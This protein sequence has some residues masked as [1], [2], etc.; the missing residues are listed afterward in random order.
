MFDPQKL[1]ELPRQT[2]MAV[3]PCGTW[4]AVGQQILNKD[5]TKYTN[6]LVRLSLADGSHQLLSTGES[7]RNPTFLHDGRLGFLSN[8]GDDEEKKHTQV[9]AFPNGVGEPQALTQEPLGVQSFVAASRSNVLVC[10]ANMLPDVAFDDQRKTMK[11]RKDKGSSALVYD[12]APVRYWDHWLP[13][14]HTHVVVYRDGQRHDLTPQAGRELEHTAVSVSPDGEWVTWL[15]R[16]LGPDRNHDSALV[17]HHLKTGEQ[18]LLFDEPHLSVGSVCWAEDSQ[19]FAFLQHR[20]ERGVHGADELCLYHVGLQSVE[21]LHTGVE[22]WLSP[23]AWLD[24][25]RL[26]LSGEA[27]TSVAVFVF[28]TH[29]HALTR[30]TTAAAGGAHRSLVVH[31][32]TLYGLRSRITHPPEPFRCPLTPETTPELIASLSGFE[33][34]EGIQIDDHRVTSTDGQPIQYFTVRADTPTQ[35]KALMWIHGGPVGQWG[36]DW[37]WRWN[38]IVGA[39]RGH[40]MVLPNPRGSTGFGQWFVEGIFGNTWGAQCFEDLTAVADEVCARSDVDP[41]QFSAMGGSFGGYM[42]NWIGTQTDRFRRL[43]THAGLFDLAMFHGVTDMPAWWAHAFNIEPYAERQ[44]FGTYSPV[45]HVRRW[46]TP[47][48]IIHGDLDYRV[49]VGEAL[50]LFDALQHQGVE[51]RLL[52]FPDENHW[53]LKPQNI[54]AWYEEVFRFL[55]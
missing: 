50:T 6:R 41:A 9:Y 26:V 43:I 10:L 12:R 4:A 25:T 52:I 19:R 46:K 54:V 29:N 31:D 55:E 36:D 40:L 21:P 1:I 24:P 11:E 17:L 45:Q 3:S 16:R 32:Q 48:L 34:P 51:S 18:T 7:D 33:L 28:D 15:V 22:H 23:V 5:A 8:R 47:T 49:P 42:T 27:D 53:I 14:T 38:P 13:P 2:S 20:R 30:I 37:H 35:G 44:A 39:L